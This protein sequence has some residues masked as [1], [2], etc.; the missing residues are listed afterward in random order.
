MRELRLLVLML[1][2]SSVV[3]AQTRQLSGILKDSKTGEGIPSAT[4][5]VKGKSFSAV[6]DAGGSFTLTVPQGAFQLDISSVGYA[7]KTVSVDANET[8][9]MLSLDQG[10]GSLDE[11]VVTALGIVKEARKVGYAVTTVKG[12]QLSVARETNVGN[13]LAGRV[14]G[15]KISSTSSGPGGTSKLLLRGMPSMNSGGAPLIV[16]NGIPVQNN[17]RGSSGEWGG[18]DNGDGLGNLNPDD[19]ESMTV[20]KGQSASALYGARASNGVI[21]ITT[22]TGRRGDYAIDYNLNYQVDKALDFTD[23]QYEYGQGLGGEKPV[24]AQQALNSAR[25]SWGERLDGSQVIQFDGNTYPYRA[26]KNNLTN[27]YRNGPTLTNTVAVSRG[28][29]MGSFRLSASNM[30]SKSILR[31]SGVTRNTVNMNIVQKITDKLQVSLVA[32]YIDERSNNRPQL[33]DGPMNANNGMF[34]AT[35]IDQKILSPGFDPVTGNEI[36][37]SDDEYVTNPYFV[38]NKY[39]NDIGRRRLIATPTVKYNFTNWL[40]AQARMGYDNSDDKVFTVA[41]WGTAYQNFLGS[42]GAQGGSRTTEVNYEGLVGASKDITTDLSFD[43][44]VGANKRV[45]RYEMQT[46]SSTGNSRWI[47]PN[48]YTI[49]NASDPIA[50]NY[51]YSKTQVNSAFYTLDFSYKDFLT[52]GTTGRYD[53]YSTLPT[54]NNTIFTPSVSASLLLH[55]FLNINKLNFAKFRTSY[56][57]TSGESTEAYRT[58]MYYTLS[59]AFNG[60]PVGNFSSDLP[61][62]L[63]KPFITTEYEVGLELR[64]FDNRLNVDIAGYTRKTTN[65]IMPAQF[66]ISTGYTAGFVPTGSTQNRGIELQITGTPIRGKDFTWVSSFN[67]TSVKNKILETDQAGNPQNLGQNR[68]TLGNAVTAYVKGLPGPQIRAYDYLYDSKGDILVDGSGLPRRGELVNMGSVLPTLYGGWNNEFTYKNFAVSFLIDYNF[69]NKILSAT[70]YYAMFRGLHK[71]TLEGRETG[72][73]VG[74]LDNGNPNTTTASAQSYYQRLS[75]EVTKLHVQDGD[76]I[77]LRQVNIGYTFSESMFSKVPLFRGATISLVGR[78]L[79][80]LMKKADNIDPEASFGANVRYF[81]IEGTSLP[82][83]RTLGFNLALKFKNGRSN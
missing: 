28:G 73:T 55:D 81:G 18:A 43:A 21:V 10:E 26:V 37:W 70:S 62:G 12:D 68:G 32:N 71:Q 46:W 15:L 27:F 78:N 47:L 61:S 45:N 42:L 66:S 59:P 35:N 58:L 63:L 69:G 2:F 16:I 24:T 82:T 50:R 22:K 52:V 30:D 54:N 80:Y 83:A 44:V 19:I 39:I 8:S 17:Q 53:A 9:L 57:Q 14:A 65:E 77:K 20:L 1:L 79:F 5:K 40:Y 23:F 64:L 51:N 56:A 72:V 75:Q 67:L 74:Y 11:V 7:T 3:S 29:D 13:S 48:F 60:A 4:L 38:I 33:S 25:L 34:L 41:P 6:T 36:R 31:N 76:F 49:S